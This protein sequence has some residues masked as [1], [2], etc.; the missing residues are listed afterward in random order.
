M[1]VQNEGARRG[2]RHIDARALRFALI[3]PCLLSAGLVGGGLLV[4]AQLPHGV[5]LP[6]GG[7]PLPLAVFLVV[8]VVVTLLLGA[9]I[10]SLGARTTLSR[11]LRRVLLGV[12]MALQ[13]ASCTLFAAALLGQSGQGGVPT[14]RVDGYVVLM[15]C[16]LAAAMGVVLALTFKPDEQ[17]GASDDAALARVLELESDPTAAN[18]RLAYAI[19]PRSSVII[20]ILLAGVFPGAILAVVS[21]WFLLGT[22]VLAL[23]VVAALCATVHVDR[24]QLTVK[25][26][27]L[28]PVVVVP[29]TD[30]AAAVS[31]DIK[32]GDYGGWGLRKHSGSETFLAYSG[33]AVVLRTAAAGRVV[34][35]A[36]NLDAADELAAILNRRAGKAPGQR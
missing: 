36:P 34:L 2:D 32:A 22:T 9:G 14:V 29:C 30:V 16:G 24:R 20:M 15:G 10:G 28:V 35:N 3:F 18:D 19:H 27:G 11:T 25:L 13:L 4:D 21:V 26:A 12:A 5:V 6:T 33:A 8:A 7:N 17:W 1:S 23:L 31:L